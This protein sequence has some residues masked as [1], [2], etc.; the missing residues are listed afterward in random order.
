MSTK[1]S[2]RSVLTDRDFQHDALR[3][4]AIAL[5]WGAGAVATLALGWWGVL[6]TWSL[7]G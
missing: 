5:T 1:E 3:L 2:V 6:L 4:A 7:L